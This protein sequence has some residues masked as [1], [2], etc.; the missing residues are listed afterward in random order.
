MI[1]LNVEGMSCEHCVKAV[2]KALAGVPGVDQVV[3]VS[4]DRGE[5]V[6][7]GQPDTDKLVAA[8]KE[9]GYD[10]RVA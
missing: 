6:V 3:D 2:T 10:A 7:E 4:L 5:A 8:V 9:E 1:K